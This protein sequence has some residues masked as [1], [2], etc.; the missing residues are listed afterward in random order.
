METN[1]SAQYP[2]RR[3]FG[4]LAPRRLQPVITDD[5]R[6]AWEIYSVQNKNWLDEGRAYQSRLGY[7]KLWRNPNDGR[8]DRRMTESEGSNSSLLGD[9]LVNFVTG[10]GQGDSY[11]ADQ[12]WH[13][14]SNARPVRDVGPSPYFPVW[15]MS[16]IL[17]SPLD[18]ANYN[19]LYSPV[20]APHI[21]HCYETGQ[22]TI[23]GIDVSEPGDTASQDI[24]TSFFAFILSYA[25]GKNVDY[26]GDP[27]SSVYIPVYDSY[28]DSKKMVG[29]LLGVMR[30]AT[31]FANILPPTSP[32]LT[33]VLE[34]TLDG[35]FTYQV[36]PTEVIYVGKGDLHDTKYK[37]KV[38][39]ATFTHL[40]IREGSTTFRLN[41]GL[42]QYVLRIYPSQEFE[43]SFTSRLPIIITISVGMVFVFTAFMV[44][45]Y[46]EFSQ[47]LSRILTATVALTCMA[48][49]TY[50]NLLQF[51]CY[52]RLVERRQQI[53]LQT[54]ERTN[55]IVT[56]LFPSQVRVR[57]MENIEEENK[58]HYFT[59]TTTK[60][61]TF[62][63]GERIDEDDE[64][65][66]RA[67]ADNFMYK[68]KPIADIFPD[69]TVMFADI[70]GF[71]S[72]SSTR[73]APQVFTLLE[74]LFKSFD[75]IARKRNVFKVCDE[76]LVDNMA[77]SCL[78]FELIRAPT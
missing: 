29:V 17:S 56:S 69:T 60:L 3:V 12:I 66:G 32:P 22:V 11:I 75:D 61:R 40:E 59:G 8:R 48:Q 73:E 13:S 76:E 10:D 27:F 34:N 9:N 55:A 6:D 57:L 7:D 20:Y 31:Y 65:H 63:D 41:E 25:V 24:T 16:P 50:L 4:R 77:E 53:V 18:L 14:N 78:Q 35:A 33:V 19:L 42:N 43:D 58:K 39:E 26:L 45:V 44:S 51:I 54:A 62:L 46:G 21:V 72:W 74:T 49:T 1:L 5:D 71:T 68:T 28:D 70:V 30:W 23:G 67:N 52:N 2:L 36:T 15:Q 38:R 64:G 37:N 47:L